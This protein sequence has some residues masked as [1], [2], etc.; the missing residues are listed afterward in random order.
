MPR[1]SDLADESEQEPKLIEGKYAII[2]VL[3]VALAGALG[4]WWYHGQLQR[5]AISLW[6]RDVAELIQT[7]PQ[8]ELLK[9]EPAGDGAKD[10][11]TNGD[12]DVLAARG[13]K[14]AIVERRDA[15][16]AAGL[17]HLRR[18]LISDKSFLWS[19][20][21]EACQPR[22]RYALRFSDG[23][24]AA[25][26]LMDF[27]CEQALLAEKNAR[28]SI[29]PMTRPDATGEEVLRRRPAGIEKFVLEQFDK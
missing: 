24:R 10:D 14:L 16:R 13:L 9:R 2:G 11:A 25:T 15:S 6:G 18:S 27:D 29:E 26:L 19:A 8:A 17:I 22:W 5:R 28:V 4:S 23:E 3:A 12:R 20:P 7:A 21:L 1:S